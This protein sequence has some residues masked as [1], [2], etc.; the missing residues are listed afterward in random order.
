MRKAGRNLHSQLGFQLAMRHL[1][2]VLRGLCGRRVPGE[3]GGRLGSALISPLSLPAGVFH[4][5]HP[6]QGLHGRAVQPAQRDLRDLWRGTKSCPPGEPPLPFTATGRDREGREAD[7]QPLP[8]LKEFKIAPSSVIPTSVSRNL[9]T[10]MAL[11]YC[12]FL[13]G[14]G[15]EEKDWNI[16]F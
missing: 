16:F 4:R 8:R 13:S 14:D 5:H 2:R 15:E 6:A 3:A 10:F 12:L 1:C 11:L 7:P 9:F